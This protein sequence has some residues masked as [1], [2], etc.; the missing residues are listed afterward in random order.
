MFTTTIGYVD[1]VGGRPMVLH[2][3]R[4]GSSTFA[5]AED[6]GSFSF[7][8]CFFLRFCQGKPNVDAGIFEEIEL[9]EI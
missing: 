9:D 1:Q 6:R 8:R 3:P 7:F 5:S 4:G 2:K